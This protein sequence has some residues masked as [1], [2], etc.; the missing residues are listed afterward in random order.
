MR[1][2]VSNADRGGSPTVREGAN[3]PNHA[4]PDGRATPL[5]K[6]TDLLNFRLLH[7]VTAL[8]DL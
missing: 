8:S 4:L 5:V 6:I 2:Q 3:L 1:C 7:L